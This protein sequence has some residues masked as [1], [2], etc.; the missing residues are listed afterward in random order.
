[1]AEDK[2]KFIKTLES[3]TV[4]E[5]VNTS[6]PKELESLQNALAKVIKPKEVKNKTEIINPFTQD[7]TK[8]KSPKDININTFTPELSAPANVQNQLETQKAVNIQ[9]ENTKLY[10]QAKQ[11]LN[12]PSSDLPPSITG[13]VPNF[14]L[15]EPD[16]N[17]VAD[18]V[19]RLRQEKALKEQQD[20]QIKAELNA[21]NEQNLQAY[22]DRKSQTLSDG[23]P[24]QDDPNMEALIN[25]KLE[26]Q[27]AEANAAV[28]AEQKAQQDIINAQTPDEVDVQI[29][30]QPLKAQNA[31]IIAQERQANQ[32]KNDLE[33][34]KAAQSQKETEIDKMY[35]DY[36]KEREQLKQAQAAKISDTD[37]WTSKSDGQKLGL[38][39][40]L[41]MSTYGSALAGTENAGLKIITQAID[42]NIEAQKFNKEMG[43][44]ELDA[45]RS[46]YI[47]R[48][49][50][51]LEKLK[52]KTIDEDRK[53]KISQFQQELALKKEEL[54]IK[55]QAEDREQAVLNRQGNI[56]S[57][58]ADSII[59][60]QGID[61]K[62][63]AI[64]SLGV[65]DY[66]KGVGKSA[67]TIKIPDEKGNKVPR[68]FL[69]N[70]VSDVDIPKVKET[71]VKAQSANKALDELMEL[72]KSMKTKAPTSAQKQRAQTLAIML[73]G[74][75]RKTII[76][77]G[78]LSE[79]EWTILKDTVK[80]PGT[81][82]SIPENIR[83]SLGVIKDKVNLKVANDLSINGYNLPES[84]S[85]IRF[86]NFKKTP[87]YKN[88]SEDEKSIM[89]KNFLR[90][91]KV[92]YIY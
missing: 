67:I 14:G 78:A 40:A 30:E 26:A 87:Q 45:L 27:N 74:D 57:I 60:G 13:E 10:E 88:A 34:E 2:D 68:V 7:L 54:N 77:E 76:G 55:Q 81:I 39:I 69:G 18:E 37:F 5:V 22:I 71:I 44:K 36:Q 35:N 80:N 61:S 28:L 38:A 86:E 83:E 6:K 51:Y 85:A 19:L 58:I 43:Q 29:A 17:L 62:T 23:Q 66:A 4:K 9:N 91:N 15:T 24:W 72:S 56:S 3:K 50:V 53:L 75:L 89:E 82:F 84:E 21:A 32:L 90:D 63:H 52:Q 16:Q 73:T 41:A 70:S 1:M 59:S 20:Q 25:Q 33:V 42:N 48:T 65:S 79:A 31:Q 8:N 11:N 47:D 46:D 92:T 49:N 12:P 64:A